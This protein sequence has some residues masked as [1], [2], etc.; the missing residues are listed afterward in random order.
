MAVEMQV[1]LLTLKTAAKPLAKQFEV[2]VMSHPVARKKVIDLAQVCAGMV[3]WHQPAACSASRI[4]PSSL[5]AAC[6]PLLTA[7]LP[8]PPPLQWLHALEVGINRGAEGKSGK[9]FVASMTEDKAVELA[10]KV[11]SEGFL[12]GVR[13]RAGGWGGAPHWLRCCC[14]YLRCVAAGCTSGLHS[15]RTAPCC[16]A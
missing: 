11:A 15:P 1:G 5:P 3:P 10:S 16:A 2:Q 9:V 14:C 7:P 8:P 4:L 6:L 12:Y 13:W